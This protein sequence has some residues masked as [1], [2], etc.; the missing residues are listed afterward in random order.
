V[1]LAV[2]RGLPVVTALLLAGAINIVAVVVLFF[3]SKSL[4]RNVGFARTRR[5][6]FPESR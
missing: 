3:W 5:L 2:E 4:M 1:W 6:V